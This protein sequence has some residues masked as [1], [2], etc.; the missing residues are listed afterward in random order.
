[1]ADDA[2]RETARL[3]RVSRTIHELVRDRVCCG[4]LR[5]FFLNGRSFYLDPLRTSNF[6]VLRDNRQ[7]SQN[8]RWN[9]LRCVQGYEIADDE[10][11]MTLDEF[12]ATYGS[13]V[14]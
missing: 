5:W 8:A 14:E 10:I 11:K 13:V 9:V 7:T 4:S 1:M 3:W 6:L 12:K 2:E